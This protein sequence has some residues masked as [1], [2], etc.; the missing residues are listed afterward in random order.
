MSRSRSCQ[1]Q[2][3]VVDSIYSLE[4][5]TQIS[6]CHCNLELFITFKALSLGPGV[7]C[8][9]HIPNLFISFCVLRLRTKVAHDIH[10]LELLIA[11]KD[12][13]SKPKFV[14]GNHNPTLFKG[15]SSLPVVIHLNNSVKLFK[16][17]RALTSCIESFMSSINLTCF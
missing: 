10:I 11:S 15:L 6:S 12:L 4:L 8:I 7:I 14:Y 5:P 17:S 1:P 2:P 9:N 16:K 13:S 3:K